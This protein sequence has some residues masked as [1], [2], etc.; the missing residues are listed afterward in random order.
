[1]RNTGL[2]FFHILSLFVAYYL[3]TIAPSNMDRSFMSTCLIL[4]VVNSLAYV[5]QKRPIF[6]NKKTKIYLRHTFVFLFCFFIVFFQYDIDYLFGLSNETDKLIWT[7]TTVVCKSMSIACMALCSLLIGFSLYRGKIKRP[8]YTYTFRMKKE[9]CVLGF[10]MLIV[11]LVFTPRAYLMGGYNEG[12]ERGGA[13]VI[14]VLLQALF[15][16]MFAIYCYEYSSGRMRRNILRELRMPVLLIICY[17]IIILMSGRRTE[18]VRM[19]MLLMIVFVYIKREKINYKLVL[20]YVIGIAFLFTAVSLVRS[21]GSAEQIREIA[22]VSPLTKE[23]AGSVNTLHVAVTNF[24]DVYPYTKGITFFP[25]FCVLV[26]GLDQFYQNFIKEAGLITTSAELI[27]MLG[28]GEGAGYGMGSSIVADVYISFG[29]I[30]VILIFIFLGYFIR[31]LEYGTFSQQF[32]PFFLV[33]SFG[34]YSQ[35]MFACRG[36]IAN[37]FLSWSYATL[38]MFILCRREKIADAK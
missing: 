11:Y 9:L 10:A 25:N 22:S 33:L 16:T 31:H 23:L 35:F 6:E 1:M 29:Y 32:S 27:T 30:G 24:P 38:L 4:V 3:F 8:V 5:F 14:L 18:A 37:M 15:I 7:D 21:G 28:V 36:T 19:G 34:C 17:M 2:L 12:I 13:N 20:V 26:P